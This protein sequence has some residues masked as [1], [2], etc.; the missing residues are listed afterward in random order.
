MYKKVLTLCSF[1]FFTTISA[2]E[3]QVLVVPRLRYDSYQFFDNQEVAR[4]VFKMK[5]HAQP[6]STVD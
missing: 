4:H 1:F 2:T 3:L 6:W 5:I